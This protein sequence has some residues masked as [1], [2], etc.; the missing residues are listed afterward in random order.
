MH[1]PTFRHEMLA[2]TDG[3]QGFVRRALPLL[4][5]ALAEDRPVLVAV[6]G[7]RV[8]LLREA[9]GEDAA[10]VEL[11]DMRSLGRNPGR[12]ISAW[13]EF[14]AAHAG[15]GRPALGIGEPIWPGRSAAELCECHN[16]E[17]L[18]NVA[19]WGGHP[20]H[21]ICPYDVDGLE[22]HVIEEAQRTHAFI[23]EDGKSRSS[24]AYAYS[25]ESPRPFAQALEPPAVE[26]RELRFSGEQLGALRRTLSA[27]AGEHGLGAAATEELVLAVNEL[28][29]NSI[30]Y[31]G[32]QG[33]LLSWHEGEA[34]VC[35]VQDSGHIDDPLIGRS[36]PA[37]NEHTGRGLWLVHQLCDLVQ[38]HSTPSGTAV[39]VHKRRAE[40][41]A[42]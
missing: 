35:E 16:H 9:L 1:A 39:R 37:P 42:G 24:E 5:T 17:A 13:H 7:E 34:L 3:A 30:R 22:D 38:I 23:D 15:G 41:S 36:R 25:D 26:V 20:W 21:L 8:A 31:G 29:T 27:W 11:L 14:L 28:A 6:P 33:K 19:F 12:I 4:T 10:R 40:Q 32:G 2:Y 18:L